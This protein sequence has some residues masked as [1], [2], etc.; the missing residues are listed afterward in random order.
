MASRELTSL[1][2][3]TLRRLGSAHYVARCRAPN[4]T[5][6]QRSAGCGR[7]PEPLQ[8]AARTDSVSGVSLCMRLRIHWCPSYQALGASASSRHVGD[9]GLESR[10][11]MPG[12]CLVDLRFKAKQ[13][14]QALFSVRLPIQ[15]VWCS[16][17]QCKAYS[18]QC[19]MHV[20]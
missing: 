11:W 18:H 6:S 9:K 7:A 19:A 1:G 16:A 15:L 5:S 3:C 8:R 13:L 14:L 4:Q 17:Y 20:M 2:I 12:L 10:Q